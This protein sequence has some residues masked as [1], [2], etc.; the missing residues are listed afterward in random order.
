MAQ[1]M[2]SRGSCSSILLNLVQWVRRRK[3]CE[4]VLPLAPRRAPDVHDETVD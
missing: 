2:R 4:E 1:P 3:N